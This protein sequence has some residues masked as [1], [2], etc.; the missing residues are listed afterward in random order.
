M[1]HQVSDHQPGQLVFPKAEEIT[2]EFSDIT[3][4]LCHPNASHR[5]GFRGANEVAPGH[6]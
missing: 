2:Q 5:L 4:A 3:N 6:A 1:V